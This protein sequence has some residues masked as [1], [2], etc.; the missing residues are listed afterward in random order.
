MNPHDAAPARAPGGEAH[1]L[2]R[3]LCPMNLRMAGGIEREHQVHDRPTRH[4]VVNDGGAFV[5][6]RGVTDCLPSLWRRW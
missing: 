2:E 4:T 5:T 6:T 1:R 3:R